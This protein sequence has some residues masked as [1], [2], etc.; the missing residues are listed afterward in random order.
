MTLS[1]LVE[2]LNHY[3]E[4]KYGDWEIR[5]DIP[6]NT[7]NKEYALYNQITKDVI[8]KIIYIEVR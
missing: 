1:K 6:I 7:R 2:F 4:D 3:P 8:N 5:F